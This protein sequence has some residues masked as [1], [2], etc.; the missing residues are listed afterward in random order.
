MPEKSQAT[1]A[2]RAKAKGTT[3]AL[4]STDVGAAYGKSTHSAKKSGDTLKDSAGFA[5]RNVSPRKPP[6]KG[7]TT[8]SRKLPLP[9]G[10]SST[11]RT[12]TLPTAAAAAY[13]KEGTRKRTTGRG[14]A[15][16]LKASKKLSGA[17]KAQKRTRT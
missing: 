1:R 2:K 10:G 16:P 12:K 6:G 9:E 8:K 3:M 14:D 5:D 4:K 13:R 17:R 7:L 11:S 15:S